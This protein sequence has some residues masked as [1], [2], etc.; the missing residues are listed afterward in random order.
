V[1][2]TSA[3]GIATLSG[4]NFKIGGQPLS[5]GALDIPQLVDDG[6][7]DVFDYSQNFN[8]YQYKGNLTGV[9]LD[10]SSFDIQISFTHF[11]DSRGDT[12]NLIIIPEPTT[13]LLLGMGGLLIR[14]R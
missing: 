11:T 14:R 9:L 3:H 13:L 7:L 12:A 4:S 5:M 8:N 6:L 10:G 2:A 1:L